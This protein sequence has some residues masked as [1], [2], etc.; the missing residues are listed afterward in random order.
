VL[1]SLTPTFRLMIAH[2][3]SDMVTP[4]AVTR[5]VLDHLPASETEE[6][7]QLRLYRGGHMFYI[8]PDSRKAFTA[9]ARTMYVAP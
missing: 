7:A 2:G 3:Y 4:Y 6:R 5:Y 9:D 8:D 1:L